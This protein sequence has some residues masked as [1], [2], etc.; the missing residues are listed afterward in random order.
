MSVKIPI[1][2]FKSLSVA[3]TYGSAIIVTALSN[4]TPSAV[5][6]AAA[7]GL[8]DGDFVEVTSGWP[9][10]DGRIAR[11]DDATTGTFKLEGFDTSDTDKYPA[12]AGIGSV[13][14]ITAWATI[15][16]PKDIAATGG[17]PKTLEVDYADGDDAQEVVTGR[18]PSRLS[19]PFRND[20]TTAGYAALKA[21]DAAGTARAFRAIRKDGNIHLYNGTV[22]L[23]D[24]SFSVGQDI[25]NT[26]TVP[27]LARSTQYA[28][29]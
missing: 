1:A 4:A 6:T 21:A 17:E 5:A 20:V 10:I 25:V 23:A 27:L 22:S 14:K 13:R 24:P 29:A 15:P 28:P 3:S 26:L 16:N 19:I 7:H 18:G 11:V 9:G 8:A 12:G 2:R